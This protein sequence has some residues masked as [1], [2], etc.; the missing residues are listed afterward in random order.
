MLGSNW[1]GLP[2]VINHIGQSKCTEK[3]RER[4]C[5]HAHTRL[6]FIEIATDTMP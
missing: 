3:Y 5:N 1:K 2:N 6:V 4:D